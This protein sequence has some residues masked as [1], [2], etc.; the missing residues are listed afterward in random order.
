MGSVLGYHL[1]GAAIIRYTS[2]E[3]AASHDAQKSK[4]TQ[5]A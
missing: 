2:A 5:D 1:S 3:P 4:T